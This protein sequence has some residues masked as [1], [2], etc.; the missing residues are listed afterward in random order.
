MPDAARDFLYHYPR[1]ARKPLERWARD[2]IKRL[3]AAEMTPDDQAYVPVITAMNN[4]ALIF[5]YLGEDREAAA[6][7]E[8]ELAWIAREASGRGPNGKAQL[9]RL[10]INPWVN[11]GRLRALQRATDDA[12]AYFAR[13]RL[14]ISGVA[15]V[16]LGPCV[17]TPQVWSRVMQIDTDTE[18]M[19]DAIYTIDSLKAYFQ[20]GDY[21]GALD[22]IRGLD[23]ISTAA[24][25]WFTKEGQVIAA[26]GLGLH[27]QV[28]AAESETPTESNLYYEA[29]LM[30]YS[31]EGRLAVGAEG[32]CKSAQ[33]LAVAVAH[34]F[35]EFVPAESRV[36]FIYRLGAALEEL[37]EQKLAFIISN[38]GLELARGLQ[39]QPL[40]CSFLKSLLALDAPPLK[41]HVEWRDSYQRLLDTCE[42][43]SIRRTEGLRPVRI[44]ANSVYRELGN[45]IR[46]ITSYE[47]G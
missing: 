10:A 37:G 23:G 15:D 21:S 5:A 19:I 14:L 13:V 28:I 44:E 9:L 17:L 1:L 22:F 30:L 36:R 7:C 34:D 24:L 18:E 11:C 6:V 32:A 45:A 3:D 25:R 38:K 29:I 40:E 16:E 12:L 47:I 43:Y 31:I 8:A 42:Y 35:L 33:E 2:L 4:A 27:Q 41:Q 26:S 20:A 39:D 46:R